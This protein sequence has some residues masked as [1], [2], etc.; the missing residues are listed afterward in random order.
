M[1]IVDL[2]HVMN[3][4]AEESEL[5]V[6]LRQAQPLRD[7]TRICCDRLGMPCRV[8]ITRVERRYE[9]RGK[10]E[11]GRLQAC[12]RVHKLRRNVALTLVQVDNAL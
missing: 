11:I 6:F 8:P 3:Q 9:C 2:S 1:K 12:V 5:L 4:T 10:R 7:G